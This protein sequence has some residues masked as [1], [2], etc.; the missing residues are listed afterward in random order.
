MLALASAGYSAGERVVLLAEAADE[1]DR[2]VA[3]WQEQRWKKANLIADAEGATVKDQLD[4]LAVRVPEQWGK[5]RGERPPPGQPPATAN[6]L[7][8]Y[9]AAALPADATVEERKTALRRELALLEAQLPPLPPLTEGD[10]D[11]K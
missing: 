2:E 3:A 1:I 5:E 11:V 8:Y 9:A 6:H 4:L 7:H 10:D